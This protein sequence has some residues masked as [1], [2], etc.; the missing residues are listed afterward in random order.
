M[1]DE[2]LEEIGPVWV[3]IDPTVIDVAVTPGAPLV[4]AP[5]GPATPTAVTTPVTTAAPAKATLPNN[6]LRFFMC[7]PSPVVRRFT[8][9]PG[10]RSLYR[11]TIV[12]TDP[13][14]RC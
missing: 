12:L 14:F 9:T 5:A 10:C 11:S 8:S 4:A 7:M 2:K 6:C 1:S 13:T 3:E